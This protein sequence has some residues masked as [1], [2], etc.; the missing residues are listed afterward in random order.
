MSALYWTLVEH[1]IDTAFDMSPYDLIGWCDLVLTSG[2]LFTVAMAPMC[3]WGV[4][5]TGV[6]MNVNKR[7]QINMY[8]DKLESLGYVSTLSASK[9]AALLSYVVQLWSV[10]SMM[11]IILDVLHHHNRRHSAWTAQGLSVWIGRKPA[12]T[13][14]TTQTPNEATVVCYW[15]VVGHTLCHTNTR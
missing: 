6:V 9:P 15:L 10:M 12:T 2:W 1:L 14:F 7:L 11:P 4:Q 8:L 5:V 13:H 3:V